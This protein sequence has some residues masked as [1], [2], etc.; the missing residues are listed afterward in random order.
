MQFNWMTAFATLALCACMRTPVNINTDP[1]IL[2]GAWVGTLNHPCQPGISDLAWSPDG[3]LIATAGTELALW[4]ATNGTR[5]R[6]IAGLNVYERYE[7][8]WSADGKRLAVLR[9]TSPGVRVQIFDPA[10]GAMIGARDFALNFQAVTLSDDLETLIGVVNATPIGQVR[11]QTSPPPPPLLPVRIVLWSVST[12][13]EKRSIALGAVSVNDLALNGDATRF[14]VGVNDATIKLFD[15][16]DTPRDL[17]VGSDNV[18]SR[19]LWNAAGTRLSA[20]LIGKLRTWNAADGAVVRD[21]DIGTNYG[22]ALTISPDEKRFAITRDPQ[23]LEL[24]NLSAGAKI[25]STA[26]TNPYL[27]GLSAV[28]F[29]PASSQLG[30]IEQNVCDLRVLNASDGSSATSVTVDQVE[31]KTITVDFQAQFKDEYSYTI[32]GTATV[33]GEPAYTVK[34]E[35]YVGYNQVLV[36]TPAPAPRGA[37]IGLY[38]ANGKVVWGQDFAGGAYSGLNTLTD[39]GSGFVGEWRAV[40]GRRFEVKLQRKP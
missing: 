37:Q 27:G 17:A 10:N 11:P 39:Y 23:T 5:V 2:R 16:T 20:L 30:F 6:T 32:T 25:S 13:L 7:L 35:G 21:L 9:F 8:H 29:N 36:Q 40:N 18:I 33:Q 28:R 1:S 31:S 15:A 24:W 4:N 3:S 34:G 22:Y 14:A 26:L 19:L 12:G 38:D